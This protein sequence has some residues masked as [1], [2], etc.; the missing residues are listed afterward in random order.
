MNE[1]Q[2]EALSAI[3]KYKSVFI[4]GPGGVGK[5]YIINYIINYILY[6]I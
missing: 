4:T 2:Q 5:S 6:I 3:V 1:K